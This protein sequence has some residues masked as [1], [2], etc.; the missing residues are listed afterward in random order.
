M[1]DGAN[2]C[3]CDD[4]DGAPEADDDERPAEN[5]PCLLEIILLVSSVLRA[6]RYSHA[7]WRML[8]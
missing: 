3:E 5:A 1:G 4:A 6:W 7:R 8:R 2:A